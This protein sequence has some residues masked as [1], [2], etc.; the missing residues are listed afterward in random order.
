MSIRGALERLKLKFHKSL[1]DSRSAVQLL[2]VAL[3]ISEPRAYRMLAGG[4]RIKLGHGQCRRLPA[5]GPSFRYRVTE[6]PSG[7]DPTDRAWKR[8]ARIGDHPELLAEL[9]GRWA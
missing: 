9:R 4:K 8:R 2:A 5:W 7:I 3:G 6:I 1:D